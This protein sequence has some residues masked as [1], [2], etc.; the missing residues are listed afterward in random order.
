MPDFERV[1]LASMPRFEWD[2]DKREATVRK[3][4]IDFRDAVEV[5]DAPSPRAAS[6]REGEARWNALGVVNG[7]ARA[8]ICAV[9]Y[10]VRDDAYRIITARR[11]RNNEQ[12]AYYQSVA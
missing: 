6:S 12:R 5:F 3:H 4:R 8:V 7:V 11:A 9:I 2:E 1:E 10:T